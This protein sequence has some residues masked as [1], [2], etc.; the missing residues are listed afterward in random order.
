[1]REDLGGCGVEEEEVMLKLEMGLD[2]WRSS[3]RERIWLRSRESKSA[4]HP[5]ERNQIIVS[6]KRNGRYLFASA[7]KLTA[8]IQNIPH[9]LM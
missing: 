2:F 7:S 8:S 4:N 9:I 1:V 6:I 3:A 5:L